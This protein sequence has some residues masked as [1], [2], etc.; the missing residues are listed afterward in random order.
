MEYYG[1]DTF[2]LWRLVCIICFFH[3][4]LP[5]TWCIYQVDKQVA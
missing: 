1:F 4:I 2:L 3:S 5:C